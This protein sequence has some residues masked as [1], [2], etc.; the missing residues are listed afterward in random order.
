MFRR[1][2]VVLAFLLPLLLPVAGQAQD[3]HE[4]FEERCGRCHGHAGPFAR[5]SLVIVEG[6]V[7]GRA[8][9]QEVGSFLQGHYGRLTENEILGLL[10]LFRF[11]IAS[12]GLYENRCLD[13]HESAKDLARNRLLVLNDQLVGRYTGRDMA[14]FL[15]RHGRLSRQEAVFMT[16]VLRWQLEGGSLPKSLPGE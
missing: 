4:L 16:D 13:C 7:V 9:R 15:M 14:E 2:L 1:L 12:S 3:L 6:Q 11:Q 5:E 10:D 8:S